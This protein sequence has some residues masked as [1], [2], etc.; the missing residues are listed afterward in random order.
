VTASAI[1]N[2]N[3]VHGSAEEREQLERTWRQ[4]DGL[5]GWL[6]TIDHKSIGKRYIVTAFVFFL[7]GGLEAAAIRTQLAGPDGRLL[8]AAT[9]TEFFTM[10]GTTM[11]FLFAVP[12]MTAIGIYFVPLMIGAR[13]VAFPRLNAYGYWVYLIGGG[14]LYA[15]FA[16]NTAPT[17]GWFSYVPLASSLYSPARGVDVW[18][19]T[20]TF[21]E[22]SSL[23]AA[24]VIIVTVF[25]HR[26]PG[27]TL[28]RI[29]L[30]VWAMLIMSFM[31]LFAM[32][33]VEMASMFLAGDRLINSRFF[34]TAQGGDPLLWQHVFW[35]FGHPEVY[36]IFIPGLGMVSAMIETF[37]RR[38]V[39]GA[40]AI[41][42]S[43]ITTGIMA[44]SLW[45]HHMF[46]AGVP[47]LGASFFTGAGA[48]IAIPTGI[49]IFC[50][51]ATLWYGRIRFSTPLL[52][53]I[54]FMFVFVI[55]GL[56][57][58]M[59]A[60]VPFDLQVHDTYFVVA[61]L[62]YV[63]I[64]GAVMPLFGAF[65]YWFPKVTGRMLSERLGRIN[66]WL[67]V[68]G[69]NLTFFPMHL[70]GLNGM[71]RRIYTYPAEAGWSNLNLAATIGAAIIAVS[72]IVFLVNVVISGRGG[73]LAGDN[74]W[75]ASSLEWATSSPPPSYGFARIP[76]V[77][78][79]AP[80]WHRPDLGAVT[81]LRTDIREVLVTRL[82][83]AAPDSR[84]DAPNESIWPLLTAIATGITFITLVFTP[85][86]IFGAVLMG[87]ALV[88]WAWPR[89]EGHEAARPEGAVR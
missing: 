43:L 21:T 54:G 37:A 38:P 50:W 6:T 75:D 16:L 65:Y 15:S 62:H 89:G 84:H 60:T 29:P 82:L 7:L 69:M 33:W 61:H 72:V 26:A 40:P 11:M 35:F 48:V 31:I 57:G 71:T 86:G 63:L 87:V 76:I 41:V 67:F 77:E 13:D 36:I 58:I 55:G 28:A 24:V 9:Y 78:S 14:L 80:L 70:L 83:D 12:M 47:R 20:V 56:S 5:W 74:P 42:L 30:F 18:C 23:I 4:R 17:A 34:D 25:K 32:P 73:E 59:V 44:F 52:W 88:G 10:H 2:G 85:K 45:V 64:G 53:V 51:I 81:G 19:Q 39:I 46:A 22:I 49:Q 1:D 66:F 27:M 8:D 3:G 68:I 79:R